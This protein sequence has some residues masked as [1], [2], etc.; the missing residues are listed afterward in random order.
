MLI[1]LSAPSTPTFSLARGGDYFY[2]VQNT[3]LL[4]AVAP[5]VLLY[6]SFVDPYIATDIDG[7]RRFFLILLVAMALP[8]LLA[9]QWRRARPIT[10]VSIS[11]NWGWLEPFATVPL[12]S[13]AAANIASSSLVS[14]LLSGNWEIY[15]SLLAPLAVLVFVRLLSVLYIQ[16]HRRFATQSIPLPVARDLHFLQTSPNI[17][18]WLSLLMP[19][20]RTEYP[21]LVAGT[22][23]GFFVFA[24]KR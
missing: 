19:N 2:A 17:F 12:T 14:D 8:I 24:C 1:T 10:A 3:L 7:L 15:V 13:L 22:I 18:L 5:V 9:Q 21:V 16:I 4:S 20:A 6:I 23:L 11:T